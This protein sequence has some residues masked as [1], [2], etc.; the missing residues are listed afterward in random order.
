MRPARSASGTQ[1][2]RSCSCWRSV[3]VF[4]G[5]RNAWRKTGYDWFP[6]EGD[7]AG[8]GGDEVVTDDDN[9]DVE[10]ILEDILGGWD[11]ESNEDDDGEDGMM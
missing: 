6:E 9:D 4:S 1:S 11:D 3:A 10:D 5:R 2:A 8:G 7:L